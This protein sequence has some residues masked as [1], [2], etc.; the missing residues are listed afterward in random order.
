MPRYIVVGHS[1]VP[2]QSIRQS[3]I[4]LEKQVLPRVTYSP[5][6]DTWPFQYL[7]TIQQ[8]VYYNV[9][10]NLE[11]IRT[12]SY[13]H[14]GTFAHNCSIE[15]WWVDGWPRGVCACFLGLLLPNIPVPHPASVFWLLAWNLLELWIL[16]VLCLVA[17]IFHVSSH[18][19]LKL[20]WLAEFPGLLNFPPSVRECPQIV[21]S[22]IKNH[23]VHLGS[24]VEH[25]WA[26]FEDMKLFW[27]TPIVPG[28][29]RWL[30]TWP[31][32]VFFVI[33]LKSKE[34]ISAISVR[35]NFQIDEK[36]VINVQYGTCDLVVNIKIYF[37]KIDV[38]LSEILAGQNC[39]KW[40]WCIISGWM[41]VQA[42]KVDKRTNSR[43]TCGR[44][45]RWRSPRRFLWEGP[46]VDMCSKEGSLIYWLDGWLRVA[47]ELMKGVSA[48]LV[49]SAFVERGDCIIMHR[50]DLGGFLG[51]QKIR[52]MNAYNRRWGSDPQPLPYQWTI[53]LIGKER[54]TIALRRLFQCAVWSGSSGWRK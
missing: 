50:S 29:L 32:I 48:E 12:G 46:D 36:L 9:W 31:L 39:I 40:W 21:Q 27:F 1:T 17:A 3:C 54:A 7:E 6:L 45:W 4:T 43:H 10:L 44:R 15:I 53:K 11:E 13:I 5:T 8:T 25:I 49:S 24:M 47:W 38:V 23:S 41:I 34:K 2:F 22:C 16:V 14:E 30:S 33:H 26:E 19:N 20:L 51:Y 35:K 37:T 28:T 42:R 18:M 52:V